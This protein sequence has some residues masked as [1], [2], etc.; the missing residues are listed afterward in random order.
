[1]VKRN[2]YMACNK[3]DPAACLTTSSHAPRLVTLLLHLGVKDTSHV[4]EIDPSI[5]CKVSAPL[6]VA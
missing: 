3:Y 5:A 4:V 2:N 1:M 6:W